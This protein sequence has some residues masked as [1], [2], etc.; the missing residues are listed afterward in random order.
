M[1]SIVIRPRNLLVPGVMVIEPALGKSRMTGPLNS[2]RA[3][4]LRDIVKTPGRNTM[5]VRFQNRPLVVPNELIVRV[6]CGWNGV[7]FGPHPADNRDKWAMGIGCENLPLDSAGKPIYS[8]DDDDDPETPNVP[9]P[10]DNS[11]P[12]W[13]VAPFTD[14]PHIPLEARPFYR[15]GY[16]MELLGS[17]WVPNSVFVEGHCY[18]PGTLVDCSPEINDYLIA[19]RDELGEF[20]ASV[21]A[22][23]YYAKSG[24]IRVPE[25]CTFRGAGMRL[26]CFMMADRAD[27][28]PWNTGFRHLLE[29]GA[30]KNIIPTFDEIPG[31]DPP[32]WD[33]GHAGS[34]SHK[35]NVEWMNDVFRNVRGTTIEDIGLYCNR[36]HQVYRTGG[37]GMAIGGGDTNFDPNTNAELAYKGF[38]LDPQPPP[39]TTPLDRPYDYWALGQQET[40]IVQQNGPIYVPSS[41]TLRRI[42]IA[43]APAYGYSLAGWSPKRGVLVEDLLLRG[44][45]SDGVDFKNL[46]ERNQSVRFNRCLH[47]HWSLGAQGT[48]LQPIVH[49][50]AKQFFFTE[51]STRFGVSR[52]A[53]ST[54]L[55]NDAPAYG[56]VC[57]FLGVGALNGIPLNRT[58][59]AINFVTMDGVPC[60]EFEA[61]DMVPH[62]VTFEIVLPPVGS[63]PGT[64][65]LPGIVHWTAHPLVEGQL[66][67]FYTD[68]VNGIMPGIVAGQNYWARDVTV[69]TFKL[70]ATKTWPGPVLGSAVIFSGKQ[71]GNH[72]AYVG[73]EA[74]A[75][76]N[77][78]GP[79]MD[80]YMPHWQEGDVAFDLRG[81]DIR[82]DECYAE[83]R[84]VGHGGFRVRGDKTMFPGAIPPHFNVLDSCAVR[85]VSEPYIV[86]TAAAARGGTAFGVQGDHVQLISPVFAGM[87]FGVGLA[88]GTLSKHV[89][90]TNPLFANC[91][92]GLL[93]GAKHVNVV[94]G[95]MTSISEQVVSVHGGAGLKV[96]D[97]PANPFRALEIGKTD[98]N[99]NDPGHGQPNGATLEFHSTNDSGNGLIIERSNI[100]GGYIIRLIPIAGTDPVEYDPDNYLI[101][102]RRQNDYNITITVGATTMVTWPGKPDTAVEGADIC[103]NNT[104]GKLPEVPPGWPGPGVSLLR[105]TIYK[106]GAFSG[107]ETFELKTAANA[108]IN[109]TGA[110]GFG[111]VMA[112]LVPAGGLAALPAFNLSTFG[113]DDEGVRAGLGGAPLV[114]YPSDPNNIASDVH[115]TGMNVDNSAISNTNTIVMGIGVNTEGGDFGQV[116]RISITDS[117]YVGSSK[118][119]WRGYGTSITWGPGNTGGIPNFPLPDQPSD[120]KVFEEFSAVGLTLRD[121]QEF[122]SPDFRLECEG[123]RQDSGASVSIVLSPSANNCINTRS[124][125]GELIR[126]GDN[127]SATTLFLSLASGFTYA[128]SLEITSF[129]QKQRSWFTFNGGVENGAPNASGVG[130]FFEAR[131]K[132]FMRGAAGASLDTL[133]VTTA[134]G[135]VVDLL[136]APVL[137]DATDANPANKMANDVATAVNAVVGFT[138][139]GTGP[140]VAGKPYFAARNEATVAI[141]SRRPMLFGEVDVV[142][143]TATGLTV[144]PFPTLTI[145]EQA[146]NGLRIGLSSPLTAGTIR[147]LRRG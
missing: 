84:I 97:L 69:D 32:T 19:A 39:G 59:L 46:S 123:I 64:P 20:T 42:M 141:V 121:I 53:L 12:P 25:G 10:I 49:M 138:P 131:A 56:E 21:G 41:L 40:G 3:Y 43:G 129:N 52:A 27:Q 13:A 58:Y 68:Q 62:P 67:I 55:I 16:W 96:K 81:A 113:G 63:P 57:T 136:A 135:V 114:V 8:I 2:P 102:A 82:C 100:P 133:K 17:E 71:Q 34:P 130:G 93:L 106:I 61:I 36:G 11:Q 99:V 37:P 112:S 94:G 29:T 145:E 83:G 48:H 125:A 26:T 117:H 111:Q 22:G 116:E 79:A 72:Q 137:W 128:L 14:W 87:G 5:M 30:G 132:F 90:I 134:Q 92:Y 33:D 7:T 118:A 23:M 31:T 77:D 127:T 18:E 54:G 146:F 74:D 15:N 126:T 9:I 78:A 104:A 108:S 98:V 139:P 35:L 115:I 1:S 119:P 38:W 70:A 45:D 147:V 143:Y 85:D 103:L 47:Y 75:T 73:F 44:A 120:W 109:T 66:V 86:R 95:L 142:S 124:H 6:D 107:A 101:W 91:S 65:N 76:L 60:V 4:Q 89:Q 88:V 51:H 144:V 50:P 105:D 24:S 80:I 110:V 140:T 28:D 122:D